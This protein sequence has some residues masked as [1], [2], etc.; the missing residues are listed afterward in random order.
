MNTV[1][2]FRKRYANESMALES[3]EMIGVLLVSRF[4]RAESAVR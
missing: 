2:L 3:A 4:L 1:W